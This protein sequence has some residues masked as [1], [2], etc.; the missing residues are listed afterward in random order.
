MLRRIFTPL[1][2][3]RLG[4]RIVRCIAGLALF[5]LGIR[6]FLASKLGVPA[7]D[8]FHQGVSRKTGIQIGI[9]IEISS[10][11]V[12]LFWIPLRQRLGL[13]TLLNALE[14][15]LV[16]FAI[17]DHMPD[18]NL[19]VWRLAYIVGAMFSI[20]IGSGLYI[21]A[22]LGPGPRDGLMLGLSQRGISIRLARTIIELT[23]LAIGLVLGGSV[24]IAT[25]VFTFG[26]GPL[27]QIFLPRL[28]LRAQ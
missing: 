10:I 4:Q 11:F 19:I 7:W 3:D 13:G 12:L 2:T 9:V 1:P 26:I 14:I 6:M 21:G 17:G 8:V 18:S 5:A 15:G 27:V 24:G 25:V 16:V 23:V 22:G 28:R 20:A